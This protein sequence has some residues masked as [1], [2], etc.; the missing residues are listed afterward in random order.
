MSR[1][2]ICLSA[3]SALAVLGA[4]KDD[5]DDVRP[6]IYIAQKVMETFPGDTLLVSG[7]ASNYVGLQHIRLQC[8]AWGIDQLHDFG[9]AE[10]KVMEFN[11][12]VPVP[13]TATFDQ[14][15]TVTV[16]DMNGLEGKQLVQL[17]FAP[18][19]QSPTLGG[20]GSYT[21]V[22]YDLEQGYG[23]LDLSLACADDRQLSSLTIKV[24]AIGYDETLEGLTG[25]TLQVERQIDFADMGSYEMP[26]SLVDAS[27]NVTDVT[28]N[29][30]V[31]PH[32][33]ECQVEDYK[34]MYVVTLLD[35]D[36]DDYYH[37]MERLD[38]Y[39][40]QC[41][42]HATTAEQGFLFVPTKSMAG[43]VYG[44]SPYA[45]FKILNNRDYVVSTKMDAAS[46]YTLTLN[47]QDH[48][49]TVEPL[50]TSSAY[51]KDKLLASGD[52]FRSF[53]DWGV[54]QKTGDYQYEVYADQDGTATPQ[55]GRYYYFVG[56]TADGGWDWNTVF[57][58]DADGHKWY[59]V[60][61]GNGALIYQSDYDGRVKNNLSVTAGSEN[62]KILFSTSYYKNEGIAKNNDMD[63]I[64]GRL[65]IDQAFG[66][67]F[68][69]GINT[70][71]SQV[72]YHDVPLGD[73]RNA[74][75]AL[76]YSAMTFLP[77]VP[78]KDEDGSYLDNPYRSIY[79]NP[80]SLLE[81]DD[82]T[83]NKDLSLSGYL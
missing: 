38:A 47:L 57:R 78:V 82:Q 68:K 64:T 11:Y 23:R 79:P 56:T 49:F 6:G 53:D 63:R 62:T 42:V 40:Y 51:N 26:L 19:T 32:E 48:S 34:Q 76:I 50:S 27:G 29:V 55:W 35:E 45:N 39:K 36:P 83:K 58:A 9:G 72:T 3:V 61:G 13:A 31:M 75:S 5:H 54:M 70:M 10:P 4:C 14:S 22:E 74:S 7:Q 28:S 21:S 25:R 69:A 60:D 37:Y 59:E 67:H 44:S 77:T 17:L 8:E 41:V 65:N 1:F 18:D 33:D 66:K 80:V 43:H 12:K 52:G 30:T 20:V 81:I 16:S 71:F 15:L 73:G 2:H 24:P 46:Y